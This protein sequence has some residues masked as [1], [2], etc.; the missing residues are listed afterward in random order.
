MSVI[1]ADNHH[2]AA[3][4]VSDFPRPSPA[5]NGFPKGPVGPVVN[6]RTR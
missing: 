6:N 3:P 5:V 1:V 4:M 2:T